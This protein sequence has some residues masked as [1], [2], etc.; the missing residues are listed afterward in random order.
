MTEGRSPKLPGTASQQLAALAEAA[1]ASGT[2]SLGQLLTAMGRTSIA[3]A[4]LILSLPALTPIP[5]PFGMV[6][7]SCLAIVSLQIIVGNESIWLPKFLARRTLSATTVN[8]IVRHTAPV[9]QRVEALLRRGRLRPLTGRTAQSLIGIPVFLL[10]VAIALPI[11]FGNILPV[12]ALIVIAMGLM[13]RD[14]LAT[15]AGIV[16]AA[17]ALGTSGGLVYGT[18]SALG[19]AIG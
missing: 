3:F 19:W 4:I 12:A 8:L 9:I 6:F 13:E 7:G 17:V 10:A 11:P 18:A 15:L 14:G 2:I 16:L 5:G 1:A